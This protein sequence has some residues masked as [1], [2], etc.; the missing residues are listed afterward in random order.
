VLRGSGSVRRWLRCTSFGD[1]ALLLFA[2]L[3]LTRVFYYAAK[4]VTG[5]NFSHSKTKFSLAK[6]I[7]SRPDR[8]VKPYKILA[9]YKF[10]QQNFPNATTYNKAEQNFGPVQISPTFPQRYYIQ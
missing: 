10:P 3:L 2:G 1:K 8:P 7:N 9:R 5:K 4:D 6:K